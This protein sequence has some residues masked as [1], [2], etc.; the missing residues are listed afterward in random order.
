M[1]PQAN[2]YLK[3]R[4]LFVETAQFFWMAFPHAA[5]IMNSAF[6]IPTEIGKYLSW[7]IKVILCSAVFKKKKSVYTCPKTL[8]KMK[9]SN[10]LR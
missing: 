10:I 9:V 7:S 4:L 8:S 6:Y 5:Q 1:F 3:I 2:F